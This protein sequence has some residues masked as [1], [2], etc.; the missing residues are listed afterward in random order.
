[1]KTEKGLV[2]AERL[3]EL[4]KFLEQI[5][6]S[7]QIILAKNFGFASLLALKGPILRSST[8]DTPL[9][10]QGYDAECFRCQLDKLIEKVKE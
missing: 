1:M 6:H 2:K 10:R 8:H 5:P 9:H 4:L 7:G 3:R